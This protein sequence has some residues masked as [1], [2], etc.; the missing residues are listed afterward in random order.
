MAENRSVAFGSGPYARVE[1][2]EDNDAALIADWIVKLICFDGEDTH[3]RHWLANKVRRGE[4]SV[5]DGGE[6]VG[7]N[8]SVILFSV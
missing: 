6:G 8:E 1:V 7:S 3:C 4:I 5:I 2:I